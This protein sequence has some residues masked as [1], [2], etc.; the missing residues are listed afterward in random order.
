MKLFSYLQKNLAFDVRALS[1]MRMGVAIII[2]LDLSIRLSDLE[3]FYSNTGAAPLSMIFQ[4]KW[5]EFYWSLHTISGLWEVQLLLFLFAACCAFLLLIGYRTRLMT[6]L[7]WVMLV[8]LHNRN[9]LI[10]QGGDDLVRMM[11]FW[12]MFLPWGKRY[13]CDRLLNTEDIEVDTRIFTLATFAYLLQITYLYTG[14]ALLKGPEW[15]TKL[16][17]LYYVYSLDQIAYPH[18]QILYYYP[19]LLK[20]LTAIAFW[21][22]MLVPVLFFIPYKNNWF[23]IT[24]VVLIIGFHSFNAF[25]LL[26]GFFPWIGMVTALG[27]LPT[28]FMNGFDARIQRWKGSIAQSFLGISTMFS[29]MLKWKQTQDA[30]KGMISQYVLGLLIVYVFAWNMGN[31]SF[32]HYKLA[33]EVRFVGYTLRIDQNWGMFAPGVFKDDG[34]F[35]MEATTYHNKTIDLFHPKD[36]LSYKKPANVTA[37]FKNDRWRKYSENFIFASNNFMRGYFCNY[38]L[39]KWNDEHPDQQVTT[40]SI[41]YFTE[42]TPPDYHYA[43]PKKDVL[44]TCVY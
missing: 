31:L 15:H 25:S 35:V 26:I 44:C 5:N 27:L 41:L 34:W 3:A 36:S 10:L 7:S 18:T 11:L 39:K 6:F 28:S 17:A 21:F 9:V 33:D 37:M 12:G 42:L 16:D 8:S 32:Y 38:Y 1:L 43:I 19:E 13:S 23:R 4:H 22:E 40:L 29:G 24:A 2:L 30:P 20:I 14:S